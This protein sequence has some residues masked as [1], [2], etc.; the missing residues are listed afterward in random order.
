MSK[1]LVVLAHSNYSSSR[2]NKALVDAVEAAGVEVHNLS[3]KYPDAHFNVAKEQAKL[4][5]ADEIVFQFPM[6]WFSTPWLLKKYLDEVFTYGWAYGTGYKLKDKKVKIAVTAGVDQAGYDNGLPVANALQ[7]LKVTLGFCQLN[8]QENYFAV[9]GVPN[10]T[11]K[12]L[13]AKANDYVQ[14]VT[15]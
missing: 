9:Y 5:A 10:L 13:L 7:W 2:A 8:L 14:F 4:E 11:D 6:N 15:K 3:I 1:K 12:D